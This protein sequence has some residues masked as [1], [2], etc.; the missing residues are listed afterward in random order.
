MYFNPMNLLMFNIHFLNYILHIKYKHLH[1][2]LYFTY[3]KHVFKYIC[4]QRLN[5]HFS[6]VGILPVYVLKL[7]LYPKCLLSAMQ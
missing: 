2:K 6:W 5:V 1:K 3:V 4:V 7:V